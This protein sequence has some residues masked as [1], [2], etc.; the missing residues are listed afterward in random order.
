MRVDS[1]RSA[2]RGPAERKGLHNWHPYYAGYSEAV[3]EDLLSFF[4]ASP[5]DIILDP[6]LGSGTTSVVCQKKNINVVGREI[7]PVMAIFS[8]SKSALLLE[9]DLPKYLN[10]IIS[11]YLKSD[12]TIAEKHD[13][14]IG[15]FINDSDYAG[16]KMIE[17]CMLAYVD[18]LQIEEIKKLF[19]T[20]F[21][22]A[23]I[24]QTL[25]VCGTFKK[26]TNPT[27]IKKLNINHE[28]QQSI[29]SVF[30]TISQAMI[31][32]LEENFRHSCSIVPDIRIGNS[33]QLDLLDN[34]VN[35]II[36]SPPYLTRIDYAVS[37]QPELLFL[38]SKLSSF[39]LIRRQTMG[40][41]IIRERIPEQSGEWGITCNTFLNKVAIHNSKAANSYYRKNFLQY[42][43]DAYQSLLEIKR[44]LRTG[45][46][47]AI[48][49]QSS[50]FKEIEIK[51]GEIYKEMGQQIGLTASILKRQTV[52]QHMA[53]IN[54]KSSQYVPNKIFYEDIVL[55]RK[56]ISMDNKDEHLLDYSDH[57]TQIEKV[58]GVEERLDK[59]KHALTVGFKNH[60]ESHESFF[61]NFQDMTAE[62]LANTF[63]EYPIIIKSVL[64]AVNVA[65]RAIKRDLEIDVDTYKA[66]ITREKAGI[67]AGYV[68]PILPAII[69]IDALLELD[70]WFYVDKEI[71]K[72]KGNWEKTIVDAL[73]KYSNKEFKKRKFT[74]DH[75]QFELDAA[76]P[77][78]GDI[79]NVG[80]DVK[81]IEARQDIHKR[82]DEIVNKALK[83][84]AVYP[85]GLFFAVIYYPIC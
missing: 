68:K 21:F 20:D 34:S 9:L 57:R 75:Q 5:S 41:P 52:K 73:S 71:R 31:R 78:E 63:F 77:A 47:A 27:W 84:K 55:L 65:G 13:N 26:G 61:I 76:Y 16:L 22:Y 14:P 1:I 3:V 30:Y 38:N 7:N 85:N 62:E 54:T 40:A 10:C 69:S 66:D 59:L 2:K 51:L 19:V 18:Q 74:V 12:N 46:K 81:R 32:D 24:F 80:V 67:L 44:V 25:R 43:S 49:V 36:T 29:S 60:L 11:A 33:T 23:S 58:E 70:R 83:F 8:R 48:I 35:Y 6:W 72:S 56:D 50:Y 37:T 15:E 64:A 53:H 28:G 82:A 42:F 39:N 79:I 17:K 45:G 4:E